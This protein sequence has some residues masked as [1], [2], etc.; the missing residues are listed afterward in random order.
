MSEFQN[1]EKENTRAT[2]LLYTRLHSKCFVGMNLFSVLTI[3]LEK[4]SYLP[5]F[6]M[7]SLR[8]REVIYP[9]LRV[10]PSSR[11]PVSHYFIGILFKSIE[12]G[13]MYPLVIPATRGAE[14][15]ESVSRLALTKLRDPISKI[16]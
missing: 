16:N 8:L 4:H 12:L 2:H 15:G 14:A 9:K 5:M 11:A 3:V 13:M 7:Q 10:H 6:Q 1:Q